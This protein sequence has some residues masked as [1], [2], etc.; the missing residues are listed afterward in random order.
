MSLVPHYMGMH[1]KK[2]TAVRTSNMNQ[3][4]T[5]MVQSNSEKTNSGRST[6]NV[7][8]CLLFKTIMQPWN[9]ITY[10]VYKNVTR[11]GGDGALWSF[12]GHPPPLEN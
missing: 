11:I 3:K 10:S 6:Q 5:Y 2:V 12:G 1:L 8:S 7:S 4:Y 9:N